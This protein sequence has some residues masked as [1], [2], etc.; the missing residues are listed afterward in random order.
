MFRKAGLALGVALVAPLAIAPA[1]EAAGAPPVDPRPAPGMPTDT[2]LYLRGLQATNDRGPAQRTRS[3]TMTQYRAQKLRWSTK[4][5]TKATKALAS[6]V[7]GRAT[8]ECANLRTPLSWS[9]L[10]KGS[11]NLHVSR[12]KATGRKA[13][14]LF[15]N[16]G[17]PGGAAGTMTLAVALTKPTLHKTHTIIGVDPRGTGG[18]TPLA[19]DADTLGVADSR[20]TTAAVRR[21]AQAGQKKFVQA[22]VKRHGSLLQHITTRN[23]VADHDLVRQLTAGPK[24]TVD[25]FGVSG[26]TWMGAWYAQLHPK[27][28][29]RVV[30]DANTEFTRDWRTSFAAY[31]MGFQ[32]RFEGQFLPWMARRHATFKAGSTTAATKA[33]YERVRA[34]AGRGKVTGLTPDAVDSILTLTMYD[35]SLFP[36]AA[37]FVAGTDARLRKAGKTDPVLPEDLMESLADFDPSELTVRTAIICN[38][39]PYTRTPASY[40]REFAKNIKA[41]PLTAGALQMIM[42]SCAYWP[43]KAQPAPRIDG[44]VGPMKLMVQTQFDPATPVEGA[45]RAHAANARTRLLTVAGQGTHGGYLTS[46]RCVDTVVTRYLTAG[47]MPAKDTTC[48]GTPLPGDGKVHPVTWKR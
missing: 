34:A 43:Y 40:E 30:L 36:I 44:R 37:Q 13:R 12:V 29:G 42:G 38:D 25:W 46:N 16:P 39:T 28:L 32:R 20:D 9:D 6:R 19:C 27:S 8:V 22:C 31:P 10:S 35:D 48:A 47:A 24:T 1:A 45:R 5:C 23:T 11:I 14:T 17:G 2:N 26:G 21:A 41:Y 4:N 18:S 15:V 33:A 3:M 7:A